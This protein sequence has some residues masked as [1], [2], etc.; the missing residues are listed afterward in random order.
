MNHTSSANPGTLY[1][2]ATPIGNLKDITF[3]A[4]EILNACQWVACEDTR[5]SQ[6]L[7]QEYGIKTKT[8]ENDPDGWYCYTAIDFVGDDV[9][10]G[11]CAGN[12]KEYNGLE[13]TQIT[14]LSLNWIY[15]GDVPEVSNTN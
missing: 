1:V 9:L 4:I 3:R 6:R 2:V 8:I 14:R 5:H 15:D 10:L 12:R 11:H 13:T 7:F